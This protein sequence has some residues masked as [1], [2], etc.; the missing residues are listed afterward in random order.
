[1]QAPLIREFQVTA[2]KVTPTSKNKLEAKTADLLLSDHF[3]ARNCLS[4]IFYFGIVKDLRALCKSCKIDASLGEAIPIYID[5]VATAYFPLLNTIRTISAM[6]VLNISSASVDI[7]Q[8]GCQLCK[9]FALNAVALN[10]ASTC[11]FGRR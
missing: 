10:S 11:F 3:E 5:S 2:K 4:G 8:F 9:L 7:I 6:Q 1:M